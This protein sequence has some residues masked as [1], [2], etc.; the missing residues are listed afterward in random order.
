MQKND[1]GQIQNTGFPRGR[2][3][4]KEYSGRFHCTCFICFQ[5]DVKQVWQTNKAAMTNSVPSCF[6]TFYCTPETFPHK[7]VKNLREL[8]SYG[9]QCTTLDTHWTQS[10][11]SHTSGNIWKDFRQRRWSPRD[12][13]SNL[14]Q[15]TGLCWVVSEPEAF[16]KALVKSF[17]PEDSHTHTQKQALVI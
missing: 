1:E 7:N 8:S 5:S 6:L 13:I 16:S 4:W 2:R 9:S 11:G 3:Q 12:A 10:Q 15:S 14:A 17:Y